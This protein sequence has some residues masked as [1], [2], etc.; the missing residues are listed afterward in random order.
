LPARAPLPPQARV[1]RTTFF[2]GYWGCVVTLLFSLGSAVIG[3]Q[4]RFWSAPRGTVV[5]RDAG[6]CTEAVRGLARDLDGGIR[7]S[8][9]AA[10]RSP[11]AALPAFRR[12][13]GDW[14]VRW[15]RVRYGC[16]LEAPRAGL[17]SL[18]TAHDRLLQHRYAAESLVRRYAA[19]EGRERAGIAAA[20]GRAGGAS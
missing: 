7:S 14:D 20:L 15:R 13:A 8:L 5:I 2:V 17:R 1:L 19:A 4:R 11:G 3:A 9:D 12:F 18:A 6:A 10:D 16:G